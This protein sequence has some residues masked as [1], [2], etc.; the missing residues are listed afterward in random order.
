MENDETANDNRQLDHGVLDPDRHYAGKQAARLC[1]H[2]REQNI[3]RNTVAAALL[4]EMFKML[5]GNPFRTRGDEG[6]LRA[7]MD[8]LWRLDNRVAAMTAQ[9][10]KGWLRLQAEKRPRFQFNRAAVPPMPPPARLAAPP[11]DYAWTQ[12]QADLIMLR[13]RPGHRYTENEVMVRY[14]RKMA[15][16]AKRRHVGGEDRF[17]NITGAKRRIIGWMRRTHGDTAIQA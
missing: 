15:G 6:A 9:W 4:D 5:D 7:D 14:R 12:H 11:P 16:A 1:E 17:R 10:D 3:D 8:F 13:M 2:L